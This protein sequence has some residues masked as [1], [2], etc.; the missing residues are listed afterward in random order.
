MGNNEVGLGEVVRLALPGVVV[1]LAEHREMFGQASNHLGLSLKTYAFQVLIRGL[2]SA[3][4]IT[5]IVPVPIRSIRIAAVVG[6]W[7]R[8]WNVLGH[9]SGTARHHGKI[10]PILQ[11]RHLRV[12]SH[13]L[14][15]TFLAFFFLLA[16]PGFDSLAA[17]ALALLDLL[18]L[19]SRQC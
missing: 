2:A 18:D 7:R 10:T 11:H 13:D 3:L 15:K 12:L 14:Q 9:A 1:G 5:R 17:F 8:R 16:L 4:L 19:T 6:G